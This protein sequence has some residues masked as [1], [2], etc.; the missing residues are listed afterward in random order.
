MTPAFPPL[1]PALPPP[2]PQPPAEPPAP[3][4]W[5]LRDLGLFIG[6]GVV[7][8]H[9]G[10]DPHQPRPVLLELVR[11]VHGRPPSHVARAPSGRCR[12]TLVTSA[13]P[14]V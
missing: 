7:A 11:P 2:A 14:Q 8:Q 12:V 1:E 4:R 3:P 9:P 10:G 6:L 13:D 5:S